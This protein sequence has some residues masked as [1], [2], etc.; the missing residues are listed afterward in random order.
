MGTTEEPLCHLLLELIIFWVIDSVHALLHQINLFLDHTSSG[1][2]KV[3][4][5]LFHALRLVFL[6]VEVKYIRFEVFNHPRED[7][8]LLKVVEAAR[9]VF[10]AVK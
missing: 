7:W 8:I 2:R 1:F 6:L 4:V 3:S 5:D 10:V 9:R